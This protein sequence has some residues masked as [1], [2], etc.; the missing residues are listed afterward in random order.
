MATPHPLIDEQHTPDGI[1]VLALNSGRLNT[2]SRPLRI[3]LIDALDRCEADPAVRAV[4]VH[5]AQG[6]FSAGADLNEFDSGVGLS[7][8]SLHR[9]IAEF[10]DGMSTPVVALIEGMA[11][12]GG[13]ELALA[14]HYRVAT[15]DAVLALPE[16]TLG[17]MPG[18]GGTQRLPRATDVRTALDLILTGRRVTADA[19]AEGRLISAFVGEDAAGDAIRFAERIVA[20]PAPRLRDVAIDTDEVRALLQLVERSTPAGPARSA[21]DAVGSG[22]DD[23]DEGFAAELRLFREL[24]TSEASSSRRHIFLAERAARR[25]Q[26]IRDR[27]SAVGRVGIVGGG[28]MG[29][30]IALAHALAGIEV[31]LVEAGE[32]ERDAS[33]RALDRETRRADRS[34]DADLLL[35]RIRL[36]TRMQDLADVDLVIE[37]VPEIMELKRDVF[38]RIV[39]CVPAGTPIASNTSSL[40]IDVLGRECGRPEDVVGLHFFSPA[41]VMRLVEVVRGA[42]TSDAVLATAISH[43]ERLGKRPVVS[44]VAPG[45]IG[46]RILEAANREVGLMLLEGATAAGIDAALERWGMRMG[47]LRV[48]DLVGND[49]PML[50]RVAAGTADR[51]EW[52]VSAE[53]VARGRLGV[54]TGAGWYR[55]EGRTP[56]P[57]AEV[58]AIVRE[59]A[60]AAGIPQVAIG[61]REIVERYVLALVNEGAAVLDEGVAARGGDI[62]VVFVDGYGFPA[63]RGGPMHFADA[64]GAPNVARIMARFARRPG[65]E[66]WRPHPLIERTAAADRLLGEWSAVA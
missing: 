28:T 19:F 62:D 56:L 54:K 5:G 53:L 61:E 7:E 27:G 64:L 6:V 30:G 60:S 10:L 17:L 1:A 65:G 18:A 34:G 57:D 13:L 16:V 66:R 47:P 42:R 14:C 29:R 37:A 31:V 33:A 45:F 51:L 22:I 3:G 8:P 12:G 40:D 50:T 15:A 20:Q 52:R 11:L 4:V 49:V 24:A 21:L 23:I 41:H 32:G 26:G 63:D 39:A 2:L 36:T 55:Y 35:E 48:L 43:V 46:N 59:V 38:D 9:T 44:A 58:D 25:V